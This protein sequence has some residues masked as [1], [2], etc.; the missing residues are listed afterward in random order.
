MGKFDYRKEY[1][2]LLDRLSI[3]A[4]LEM[5]NPKLYS[6]R[7]LLA[8]INYRLGKLNC[9]QMTESELNRSLA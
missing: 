5:A 6:D 8:M 1:E 7:K 9:I 3:E 2:D 4:G